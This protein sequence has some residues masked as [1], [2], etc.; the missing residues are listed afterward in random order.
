MANEISVTANLTVNNGNYNA[1]RTVSTS[2]NQSSSGFDTQLIQVTTG[3]VNL[4]PVGIGTEGWIWFKNLDS[5]NYLDWG[6][7]S[8]HIG[9]MQPGEYA[10]FRMLSTATLNLVAN[11]ATCE[12][13]VFLLEN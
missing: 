6:V 5:T 9:R 3:G 7:A 10:V 8:N 4:S 2:F 1:S 11:T 12:V 13:E